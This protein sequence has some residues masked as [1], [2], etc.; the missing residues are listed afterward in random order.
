MRH[1]VILLSLLS[2]ETMSGCNNTERLDQQ[3]A[4]R[5]EQRKQESDCYWDQRRL[6]EEKAQQVWNAKV[7]SLHDGRV[8]IGMTWPA[9]REIWGEPTSTRESNISGTA[10]WTVTYKE[11][12]WRSHYFTFVNGKLQSWDSPG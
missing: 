5:A 3:E 8:K 1:T 10:I 6:E 12:Y 7:A 9:L 11:D 2:I 4:L